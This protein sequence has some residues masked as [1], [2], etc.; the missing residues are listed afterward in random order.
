MFKSDSFQH[1]NQHDIH[2][3]SSSKILIYQYLRA[4]FNKFTLYNKANNKKFIHKE[5]NICRL[6]FEKEAENIKSMLL[7]S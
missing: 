2:K 3:F 5:M 4:V 1:H 7:Y 6:L